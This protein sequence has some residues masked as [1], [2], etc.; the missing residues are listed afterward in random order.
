MPSPTAGRTPS[1]SPPPILV[2]VVE[3]L[4]ISAIRTRY[5]ATPFWRAA[6]QV[7]IGGTLVLIA[8]IAIG[9]A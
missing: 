5:M 3:L 4:V 6:M 9:S 2:V 8:G 7:I 1:G